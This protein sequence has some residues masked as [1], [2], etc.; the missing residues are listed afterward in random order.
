M[1]GDHLRVLIHLIITGMSLTYNKA[2]TPLTKGSLF[3]PEVQLLL[4]KYYISV[5]GFYI[6]LY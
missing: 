2:S 6:I 3:Y 5:F 1:L 4:F